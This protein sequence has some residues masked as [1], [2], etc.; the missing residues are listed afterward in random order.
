[1]SIFET[2]ELI[3]LHSNK[4]KDV[5]LPINQILELQIGNLQA[6]ASLLKIILMY[7]QSN[8]EGTL[9]RDE[10][11]CSGASFSGIIL[12]SSG[13]YWVHAV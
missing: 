12:P 9:M 3:K 5:T 2:K 4:I 1:M 6:V 7:C 13:P 10:E 11:R 8:K